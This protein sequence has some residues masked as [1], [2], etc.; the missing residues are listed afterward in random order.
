MKSILRKSNKP[1][2]ITLPDFK[3]YYKAIVIK[4]AWNWQKYTFISQWNRYEPRNKP[5][6]CG[7]RTKQYKT[8]KE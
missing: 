8:V 4:I 6:I 3:L 2:G 1:G 7:Q 5:C